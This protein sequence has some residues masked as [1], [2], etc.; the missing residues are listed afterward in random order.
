MKPT[1][2]EEREMLRQMLEHKEQLLDY[3][4]GGTFC[5][6]FTPT[7]SAAF[8]KLGSKY[9]YDPEFS[10]AL[11]S[12]EFKSAKTRSKRK[13]PVDYSKVQIQFAPPLRK[14]NEVKP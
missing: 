5:L 14:V 12:Y 11:G 8:A 7:E 4:G 13:P 9:K 2:A 3:I 1:E 6:P 10:D